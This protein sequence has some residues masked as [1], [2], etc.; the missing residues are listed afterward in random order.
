MSITNH[1]QNGSYLS[2]ALQFR[3]GAFKPLGHLQRVSGR[4]LAHPVRVDGLHL[5]AED[6]RNLCPVHL[7]FCQTFKVDVCLLDHLY[8]LLHSPSISTIPQTT[9]R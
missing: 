2:I 7:D 6:V 9:R 8:L 3:F 1:D 4:S 5:S